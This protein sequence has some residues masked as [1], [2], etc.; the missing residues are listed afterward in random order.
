M[1]RSQTG[2]GAIAAIMILVILAALSAAIVSFSTGQ[3]MASA[4]DVLASRAWQ[5]A[6]AGTEGGLY[7]ALKTAVCGTETWTSADDPVFKVT[8]ACTSSIYNDGE[9]VPGT[10]RQLR[11]FRVVATACNGSVATCP[12]DAASAGA[13]YVERQR[14]AVAYCEWNGAACTGP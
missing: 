10:A 8:V 6:S 11:V 7:K 4:Q 3:Q 9:S 12:D 5:V 13:G 2:L 14:I 1:K